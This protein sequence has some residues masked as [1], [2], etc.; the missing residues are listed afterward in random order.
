[1]CPPF[2]V[3]AQEFQRQRRQVLPDASFGRLTARHDQR[4]RPTGWPAIPAER[5]GQETKVT[6]KG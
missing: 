1:M 6:R 4:R 3:N 2:P 5:H